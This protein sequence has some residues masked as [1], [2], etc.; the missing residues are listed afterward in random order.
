MQADT[1]SAENDKQQGETL[2]VEVMRGGKRVAPAPTL[3]QIRAHAAGELAKLPEPLRRLEP[4]DYPV[5]IAGALHA[6]AAEA[7]RHNLGR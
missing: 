6:L 1:L 2:I 4:F 5:T 7:D 3:A